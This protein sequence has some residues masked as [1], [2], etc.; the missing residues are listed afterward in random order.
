MNKTKNLFFFKFF[1]F[2]QNAHLAKILEIKYPFNK[3]IDNLILFKLLLK[4]MR[5]G[6]R[7]LAKILLNREIISGEKYRHDDYEK[8]K[9]KIRK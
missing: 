1:Y 6:G 3:K 2:W 5:G 8:K 9:K 4:I 7:L